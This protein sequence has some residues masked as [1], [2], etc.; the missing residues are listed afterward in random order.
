MPSG[1]R[2]PYRMVYTIYRRKY[3]PVRI[4][5][6]RYKLY[7]ENSLAIYIANEINVYSLATLTQLAGPRG[8]TLLF[9]RQRHHDSESDARTTHSTQPHEPEHAHPAWRLGLARAHTHL[10]TAHVCN[11]HVP[12]RRTVV[13]HVAQTPLAS[14]Y[15]TPTMRDTRHNST[16]PHTHA[17]RAL[18]TMSHDS[19]PRY[20]SKHPRRGPTRHETRSAVGGALEPHEAC[21][22]RRCHVRECAHDPQGWARAKDAPPRRS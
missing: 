1:I 7:T 4:R 14:A 2:Y 21:V 3:E 16:L 12:N 10:R 19:T 15:A 18:I 8:G 17:Y 13:T 6:I 20:D 9:T 5:R 22:P 11:C